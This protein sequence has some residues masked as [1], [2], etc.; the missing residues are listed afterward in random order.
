[1]ETERANPKMSIFLFNLSLA[2]AKAERLPIIRENRVVDEATVKL[3]AIIL[4]KGCF[5]K[6]AM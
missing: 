4:K 3:F 1:M 6:T 2:K 5:L